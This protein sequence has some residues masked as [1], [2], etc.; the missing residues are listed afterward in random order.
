M[1]R[2]TR[3]E[4]KD[5]TIIQILNSTKKLANKGK[6]C[7]ESNEKL[8]VQDNIG[9]FMKHPDKTISELAKETL[10]RVLR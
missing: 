8:Y 6:V 2:Y 10:D 5:D 4:L 9:H 7:I 3:N 1:N